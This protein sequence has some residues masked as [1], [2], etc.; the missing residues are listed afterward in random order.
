MCFSGAIILQC[1]NTSWPDIKWCFSGQAKLEM[2][3][4]FYKL[5][6]TKLNAT[7]TFNFGKPHF[8]LPYSTI[9]AM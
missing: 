6:K 3:Y 8:A 1:H 4:I 9:I 5:V 7:N 2:L